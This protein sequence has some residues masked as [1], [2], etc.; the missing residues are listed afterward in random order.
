MR[1]GHPGHAAWRA[2]VVF[3][4][5]FAVFLTAGSR[6]PARN[7]SI[8]D[9]P[10]YAVT[11]W[12]LVER[13]VFTDGVFA[14]GPGAAV[15]PPGMWLAPGYPVLLAGLMRLDPAL[16][17]AATCLVTRLAEGADA[18]GCPPARRFVLPVNMAFV[19]SAIAL[20]YLAAARIAPASRWAPSLAAGLTGVAL[21]AYLRTLGLAMTESLGLFLFAAAGFLFLLAW[22]E[23][24]RWT[25][26][27]AGFALGLLV[28]TRPSHVALI[29]FALLALLLLAPRGT[30]WSGRLLLPVIFALGLGAATLPWMVRNQVTLGRFAL[31]ANYG[32]A[33]L[34]ERLAYNRMTPTEFAQS[35]VFWLPDF[36]DDLARR[37]FGNDLIEKLDWDRPNSFYAQGQ[38]DRHAA[39]GAAGE[40]QDRMGEI[41]RRQVLG[42]P[43]AHAMATVS[44]GYRGLWVGRYA[45]FLLLALL[46]LGL[47]AAARLGAL[48]PLLVYAAPAWIMLGVH[49]AASV[50]QERYN[51]ALALGLSVGAGF[52][53]ERLA[54]R[55]GVRHA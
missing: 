45:S 55:R 48:R 38:R 22:Q 46:P 16:H 2:G 52:A 7:L 19:A 44:L 31:T 41:L 9:Q 1:V 39:L 35:F 40:L 15:R 54:V 25:A 47:M 34:V 42:D 14:R 49:A 50:N 27:A 26:L 4:A 18:G 8:F 5:C 29:A 10:F 43:V 20:N 24:G 13:G 30:G 23:R 33:V 3:L 51:L 32:P 53:M 37:L 28:L 11:A 6:T 21:F 12:D 17:D 36:G